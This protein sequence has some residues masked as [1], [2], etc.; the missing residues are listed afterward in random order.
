[1]TAVRIVRM[2]SPRYITG[3]VLW[4]CKGCLA[5]RK[6]EGWTLNGSK[7]APHELSCDDCRRRETA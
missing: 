1:M 7:P 3:V 2:D 4:L 6:R 5:K